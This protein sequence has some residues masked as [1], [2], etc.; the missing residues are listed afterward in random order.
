M[1]A[2]AWL[3]AFTF[4]V[5]SAFHVFW[6]FGVKLG[7]SGVIPEV[8]GAPSFHPSRGSTLGVAFL[9]ALAACVVLA[10]AGLL[11]VPLPA[12]V[13]RFAAFALGI[14]F[15]LR[16]VGDFRLVGFFKS[17]RGTKFAAND[18]RFFSPLCIAIGVATLW[19]AA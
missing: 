3:L 2:V 13:A 10:R 18:T 9:L 7:E 5:L 14:T 15:V 4:G 12:F 11:A 17:V 6:A 1:T 8:D 16:A 19:L